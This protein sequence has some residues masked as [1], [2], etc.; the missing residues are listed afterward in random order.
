MIDSYEKLKEC[1]QIEKEQYKNIGYKGKF[2]AAVTQ[3]EIGKI[4]AYD[5]A[6][7]KDEYYTNTSSESVVK[8]LKALYWRRKHNL[9]GCKMGISIPVNT[10]GK[11]LLIYHS[12]G[13]IVHRQARCGEFCKLHG[14]NCIGNNGSENGSEN[15]PVIGDKLDMG[16]GAIIIGGITLADEVKVAAGAVVCKSCN[17]KGAVLIGIPACEN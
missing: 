9:L 15:V 7:R 10:F 5:V 17:N 8:R 13:I 4:V 3:C 2:H 6:L 11:G 1:L 16:V 14:M 12:Q